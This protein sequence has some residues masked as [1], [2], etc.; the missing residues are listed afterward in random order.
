MR[1]SDDP[2]LPIRG[3]ID[4]D[5]T[6]YQRLYE[7]FRG[8]AQAVNGNDDAISEN[9]KKIA[10][11]ENAIIP[12]QVMWAG[13]GIGEVFY[14]RDD[15]PGT[16]V[17]PVDD[18]GFR[19]IKLSANDAY[20]AGVLSN[21]TIS[22]SAPLIV[23]TATISLLDS[24]L[25]GLTI[26]LLNTE[27]RFLRSG[28]S[29]ALKDSQNLSH[30]HG[31]TMG[32]SGNHSHAIGGSATVLLAGGG[33]GYGVAS[34]STSTG[35]GGNHVHTLTIDAEGGTEARPRSQEATAYMRIK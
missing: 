33:I 18:T 21:E 14:L 25:N 35:L 7:L 31:A 17:P 3:G 10:E 12:S 28:Q 34:G 8:I 2:R 24:S 30:L 13:K 9:A 19:F 22:G 26:N 20:N 6:L 1:L 11:I 16:T 32:G 29:G 4:Y 23:A 5:K 15:L 27:G